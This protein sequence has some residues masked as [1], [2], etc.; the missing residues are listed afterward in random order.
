[1]EFVYLP[2]NLRLIMNI[3]KSSFFFI[4]LFISTFAQAQV[5]HDIWDGLTKKYVSATG[6]VNYGG[7]NKDE[8]SL[9]TYLAL[10]SSNP[11]KASWSKDERL[12]YWINAYNAFTV[13]LILNYQKDNIKSIKD[14]G[15]SIKI[16]FVN[17]PWDIKFFKIGGKSMDLNEIEHGI[18]RKQFNDA[19]IHFA[20][21]CAAV[22]CPPLRNEAFVA[23]KLNAQLDDQGVKFLNDPTKNKVAANTATVSKLFTWYGGDFK[24]TKPVIEWINQ[25]SRVKLQKN[26]SISYMDYLWD[27][28]GSF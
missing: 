28:N 14:I 26:G 12:A 2:I 20:L 18:I 6:R 7:F 10:L 17:T 23:S 8:K 1:M 24:K 25:Y 21:V 3:L 27:L 15:S 5:T 11:P 19:R 22:S 13:K 16:P 9:D 4:C